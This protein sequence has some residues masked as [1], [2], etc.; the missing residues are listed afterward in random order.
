[1]KTWGFLISVAEYDDCDKNLSFV[2][3]GKTK[4]KGDFSCTQDGMMMQLLSLRQG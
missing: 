3:R 2:H 1:M 4:R